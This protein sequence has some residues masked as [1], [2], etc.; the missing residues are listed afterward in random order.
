MNPT[1]T[2]LSR[3]LALLAAMT[4][5]ASALAADIAPG[6]KSVKIT[7]GTASLELS[8]PKL[9]LTGGD[10]NKPL[11]PAAVKLEDGKATLT[12]D[13]GVT[14]VVEK[15]GDG[16]RLVFTGGESV[17]KVRMEMLVPTAYGTGGTWKAGEGEAKA[18]PAEKPPKAFLYQ[19]HATSLQFTAPSGETLAFTIPPY[20]YQQLQDNRV[21]NWST[22]Q[23]VFWMPFNR[24]NPTF[25]ITI[26]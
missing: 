18:F 13:G 21:W 8:Y 5:A 9:H 6:E 1:T 25:A 15:A 12:Y 17:E 10:A 4:L 14:A 7:A 16:L 11:S 2:T 23:W 20:S 26:K 19:G 24:D 22:F 3:G